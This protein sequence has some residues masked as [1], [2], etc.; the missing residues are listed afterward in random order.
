VNSQNVERHENL[1]TFIVD[2]MV[3]PVVLENMLLASH[4]REIQVVNGLKRGLLDRAIEGEH[5]GTIIHA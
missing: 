1:A 2:D 4:V 3:E 5:V